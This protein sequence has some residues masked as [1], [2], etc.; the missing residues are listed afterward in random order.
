MLFHSQI[1]HDLNTL[2]LLCIPSAHSSFHTRT[3]DPSPVTPH[4]SIMGAHAFH[5][6]LK[7]PSTQSYKIWLSESD[8]HACSAKPSIN[9]PVN[10]LTGMPKEYHG[11]ADVFSKQKTQ[12]LSNHYPYNL[13][14]KLKEGTTPPSPRHLYSLSALEQEMLQTFIQEN[15]D[16]SFIHPSKSS[17]GM[18]VLFTKKKNGSLCLCCNFHGLKHEERSI[19]SSAHQ[20]PSQYLLQ[21]MPLHQNQP[22]S[23]IPSCLSHQGGGVKNCV[24]DEVWFLQVVGHSRGT[25][26]CSCCI[27]AIHEQHL[28]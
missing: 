7:Q 9:M 25:H 16:F 15:L 19:P 2:L 28:Q 27:S 22:P 10:S 23:C 4:I 8:F 21:R 14:I 5:S 1:W 12:E 18:P 3:P 26:Q 20:Q 6:I 24:L 13:K 11:F 17:H